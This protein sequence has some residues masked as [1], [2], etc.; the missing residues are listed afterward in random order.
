[1][2]IEQL[3]NH[4]IPPQVIGET[5]I[6]STYQVTST[7]LR[8]LMAKVILVGQA[9]LAILA[10]I[11]L[12]RS[13][14]LLIQKS[15]TAFSS[16]ASGAYLAKSKDKH[17][18]VDVALA[19]GAVALA[20]L[21]LA[22]VIIGNPN[23]FIAATLSEAALLYGATIRTLCDPNKEP[24]EAL[25]TLCYA[26]TATI[27]AAGMI[28][29]NFAV[30]LAASS[31]GLAATLGLVLKSLYKK[32]WVQAGCYSMMAG[33]QSWGL[34]TQITNFIAYEKQKEEQANATRRWKEFLLSL[35]DEKTTTGFQEKWQFASDHLP[36]GYEINGIKVLS[37][38]VYNKNATGWLP[39][40]KMDKS[41]IGMEDVRVPG[42]TDG[43]TLR[44]ISVS[45]EVV[46]MLGNGD[47]MALQECSGAFLTELQKHLPDHFKMIIPLQSGSKDD[48]NV[49][50]YNA[51]KLPLQESFPAFA[52]PNAAPNRTVTVAI[53]NELIVVNAHV[54]GDPNAPGLEDLTHYLSQFGTNRAVISIGDNNFGPWEAPSLEG[55]HTIPAPYPTQGG[56]K[57][58][59]RDT[60]HL[61]WGI[62]NRAVR[63]MS[64]DEVRPGLS[65]IA[66]LISDHNAA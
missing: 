40:M 19:T 46:A 64:A 62:T 28:T 33:A 6:A 9:V 47:V 38:N 11:P 22:S 35:K 29:G 5:S 30:T 10:N 7:N 54:P 24:E 66:K 21:G 36:I 26:I 57:I 65:S 34:A 4:P 31:L 2:S 52:Y 48:F 49:T 45:K 14:V 25:T 23:L 8:P 41:L 12:M 60:S 42:A 3:F 39:E 13:I 17:A 27:A 53:F 43:L 16:V 61:D 59:S 55:F 50:I 15:I 63:P 58:H 51:N 56:T 32:E 18:W 37:W 44:D 20:A 1:M